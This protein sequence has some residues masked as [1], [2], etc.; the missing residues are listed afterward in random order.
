VPRPPQAIS[1]IDFDESFFDAVIERAGGCRLEDKYTP[2]KDTQ[3][4]DYLIQQ[5]ALE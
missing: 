5:W 3:H 4:V 1:G 2:P